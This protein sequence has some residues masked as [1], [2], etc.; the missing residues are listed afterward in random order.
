M[1]KRVG[2]EEDN[3][4]VKCHSFA[5]FLKSQGPE[6]PSRV[7]TCL[8]KLK[9]GIEA[10]HGNVINN[11][12]VKTHQNDA[13]RVCWTP[14]AKAWHSSVVLHSIRMALLNKPYGV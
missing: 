12:L 2:E 14:P 5:R 9:L 10:E 8:K 11:Y 13:F 4:L 7:N 6:K 1:E 3:F